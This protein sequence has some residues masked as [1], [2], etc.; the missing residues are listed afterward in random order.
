VS[1]DDAVT[2][3]VR[4]IFL[5][6]FVPVCMWSAT[7]W[8][9]GSPVVCVI[10]RGAVWAH[11]EGVYYHSSRLVYA[12]FVWGEF[13]MGEGGCVGFLGTELESNMCVSGVLIW[14]GSSPI[15]SVWLQFYALRFHENLAGH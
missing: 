13:Y 3:F 6:M 4:E 12:T 5:Y 7:R 14:L 15:C 2:Y 8:P 10:E 1:R 9:C 11:A